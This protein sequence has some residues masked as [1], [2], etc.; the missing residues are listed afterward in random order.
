[1]SKPTAVLISDIHYNINTL[2]LADAALRQAVVKAAELKIP[3][4][5]AGDLHD[6][7]AL[8]RAEC[9]AA[10]IDTFDYG[11]KLGVNSYVIV[12]NH[13]LQNEKGQADALAF[14]EGATTLVREPLGVPGVG[15]LLPYYTDS[16]KLRAVLNTRPAKT[17]I[18][19]QGVMGAAMGHYVKDTSSLPP[20]AFEDFRVV[21]GH[22]HKAQDIKTGRPRKGAVG[23]FSYI[24]NPY[25]LTFG[26]AHDGPKGFCV[27]M[28]DG[29][30]ERIPSNLRKHI[31]LEAHM[32]SWWE[33]S[34]EKF[35]PGDLLWLKISGT[36]ADLDTLKKEDVAS[37]LK[38]TNFK[39]D[40]IYTGTPSLEEKS[41]TMTGE[42]VLDALIDSAP[43]GSAVHKKK[44][45]ALWR[46]IL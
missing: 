38:T 7:K 18:M 26:E 1:M 36:K 25:T 30:L 11:F 31:V 20:E 42:E 27:L 32:D 12:G 5:V 9:I 41:D 23:L 45:K 21:S 39:L 17:L 37:L 46:E 4:I 6:T 14:L 34:Y 24:G 43:G 15:Y 2:S 35:S 33:I 44:L 8:L 16:E 29:S 40:K 10:I 28:D 19:H 13:D 22:Y 3:L